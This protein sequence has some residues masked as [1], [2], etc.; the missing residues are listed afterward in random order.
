MENN[1]LKIIAEGVVGAI[2]IAF[3]ILLSPLLRPWYRR[4]GASDEEISRA[5]PGDEY[6]PRPKS[7]L[8]MAISVHAPA[9]ALWPWFVQ[10]GCQRGAC[11]TTAAS[12]AQT[13]SCRS[14]RT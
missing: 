13:A 12:P 5:L 11:S 3:T 9:E 4:W 6:V 7:E 1:K 14:T 2:G 10:L 8:T